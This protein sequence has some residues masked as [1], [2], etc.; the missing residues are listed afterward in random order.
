MAELV[1]SL[2]NYSRL[3]KDK[4]NGAVDEVDLDTVIAEVKEDFE[5]LIEE[6]RAVINCAGLPVVSGNRMQLGQLFSNLISNSLK[7][8]KADPV[9]EINCTQ[10]PC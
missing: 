3:A 2:L 6:R 9:I 4:G 8:S 1:R 7:F 10:N 5:L